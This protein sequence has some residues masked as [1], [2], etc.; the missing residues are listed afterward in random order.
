MRARKAGLFRNSRAT[1]VAL[2]DFSGPR[3]RVVV[4]VTG[5]VLEGELG[6]AH[7]GKRR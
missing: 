7:C 4:P 6:I 5:D 3:G 1:F 2:P